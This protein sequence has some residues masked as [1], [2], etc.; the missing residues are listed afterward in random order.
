MAVTPSYWH[1]WKGKILKA[2]SIN[3]AYTWT[4]IKEKSG[5]APDELNTAL[6]ELYELN[7]IIKEDNSYRILTPSLIK[8]YTEYDAYIRKQTEIKK[9]ITPE[10]V[11]KARIWLK[12]YKDY[13]KE[14]KIEGTIIEKMINLFFLNIGCGYGKIKCKIMI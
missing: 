11:Q 12:K 6:S 9:G 10:Q 1:S 8:E 3:D 5:L 13:K 14:K 7:H 2:I 4:E